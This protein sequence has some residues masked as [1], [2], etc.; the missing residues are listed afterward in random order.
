MSFLPITSSTKLCFVKASLMPMKQS[1]IIDYV[2]L[3]VLERK[4]Y[5]SIPSYLRTVPNPGRRN[6]RIS[7]HMIVS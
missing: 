2:F 4:S 7:I 3:L 5:A 1:F 6:A